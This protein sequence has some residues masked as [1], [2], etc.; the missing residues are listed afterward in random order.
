MVTSGLRVHTYVCIFTNEQPLPPHTQGGGRR[1]PLRAGKET[2][3]R[4]ATQTTF[5]VWPQNPN[6]EFTEQELS[7]PLLLQDQVLE[8]CRLTQ[9]KRGACSVT[10]TSHRP[11]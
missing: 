4:R 6:L 1:D 10:Q 9:Q 11:G 7:S 5:C 8:V 2:V 3:P